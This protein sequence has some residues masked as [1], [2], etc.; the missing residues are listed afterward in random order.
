MNRITY[1]LSKV[2]EEAAEVAQMAAKTQQFGMDERYRQGPSNAERLRA[3][4]TDL[5]TVFG[6]LSV[7]TGFDF[8]V[9]VRQMSA[10]K[11]DKVDHY[12]RLALKNDD[13][14]REP[15]F[16]ALDWAARNITVWHE[17]AHGSDS[18]GVSWFATQAGPRNRKAQGFCIQKNG[19]TYGVLTSAWAARRTMLAFTGEVAEWPDTLS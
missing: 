11:A 6:M 4:L 17:N 7:E 3:E 9:A 8:G 14:A 1:L 2:A 10:E 15:K 16:D 19:E 18:T 12:Y 5:L 13:T